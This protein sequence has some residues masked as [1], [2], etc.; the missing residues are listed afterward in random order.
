MIER[1]LDVP[2]RSSK[3]KN[4]KELESKLLLIKNSIRQNINM[5]NEVF[6]DRSIYSQE[7]AKALGDQES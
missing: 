3:V 2:L 7:E 6:N 1:I 5:Q 4:N